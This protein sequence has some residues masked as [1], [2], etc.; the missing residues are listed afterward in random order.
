MMGV[1]LSITHQRGGKCLDIFFNDC[2]K[3][4]FVVYIHERMYLFKKAYDLYI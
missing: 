4:C 1:C 3:N 2:V